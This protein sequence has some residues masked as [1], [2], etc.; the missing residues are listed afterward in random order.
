[1]SAVEARTQQSEKLL[2]FHRDVDAILQEYKATLTSLDYQLP[3]YTREQLTDRIQGKIPLV[4]IH[5]IK[6]PKEFIDRLFEDICMVALKYENGTGPSIHRLRLS[7][8]SLDGLIRCAVSRDLD[9]MM[10]LARELD[11]D[12]DWLY[13]LGMA[14]A[15][16]LLET[17]SDHFRTDILEPCRDR[18]N[19]PVCDNPPAM[20][21]LSRPHGQRILWCGACG[22]EWTGGRGRCHFCAN[23]DPNKLGFL[24][25][26]DQ[27]Q[28]RVDFCEVCD[29]HMKVV[30]ERET[31][32]ELDM[33]FEQF[34]TQYLDIL[35]SDERNN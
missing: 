14:L 20:A 31:A 15:R 12:V 18:P 34:A 30:D 28:Y 11:Q 33:F 13:F 8:L 10:S 29:R 17:Y 19:C 5:D 35:A 24:F 22:S 9:G 21:K 7:G 4:N 26:E 3:D 2:A 32:G 25:A 1:M 27:K 23:D 16:P 6:I